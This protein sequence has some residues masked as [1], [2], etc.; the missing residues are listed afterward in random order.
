MSRQVFVVDDHPV[1]GEG[2][3][4]MLDGT[5][6]NVMEGAVDAKSAFEFLAENRPD[7]V[8][9]DVRLNGEDGLKTL[10]KIQELY[11]DL[12]VVLYSAYDNPTYLARGVALGASGFVLKSAPRERLIEALQ[13]V[14]EGNPAWTRDELRCVTGPMSID[15]GNPELE[16]PL[17]HRESEVMRQMAHGLT[18]KE[19]AK[20]L[21]ISYETV[22]EHV[23]HILRKLGVKDRTQAAVWA[24]KRK[25]V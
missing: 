24:V 8:L 20:V 2:V 13:T 7:V 10:A 25:F 21:C 15:R 1:V 6:L 16:V 5:T 9:L 4:I 11:P 3:R 17:T 12:P 22:K 18:N 14:A 19:I 23:Q